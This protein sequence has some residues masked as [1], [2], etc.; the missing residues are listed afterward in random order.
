MQLL[1]LKSYYPC[2]EVDEFWT[3]VGNKSKKY[4]LIYANEREN[5]EIVV[6]VWGSEIEKQLNA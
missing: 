2:L 4:W 1:L 3:Y 6:Y 5:A